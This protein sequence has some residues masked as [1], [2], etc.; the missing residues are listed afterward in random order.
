MKYA[1][2]FVQVVLALLFLFAGGMKLV[3]PVEALG[4][5]FD[6]SEKRDAR[7][8]RSDDCRYPILAA[9]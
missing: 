5:P 8:E 1:L 3:V 2:W 4:L 7:R 6:K 9:Q